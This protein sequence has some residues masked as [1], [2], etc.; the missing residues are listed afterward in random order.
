M[1]CISHNA[2][3]ARRIYDTVDRTKLAGITLLQVDGNVSLS[4]P[5][6][7][8]GHASKEHPDVKVIKEW[9]Q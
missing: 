1:H 4:R 2:D 9:M 8:F 3:E 7:L 5:Y 6:D